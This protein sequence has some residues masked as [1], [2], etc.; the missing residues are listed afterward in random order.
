MNTLEEI[1]EALEADSDSLILL[2][3]WLKDNKESFLHTGSHAFYG[4]IGTDYDY[5][6]KFS[7]L[8][9]EP[10]ELRAEARHTSCSEDYMDEADKELIRTIRDDKDNYII[11]TDLGYQQWNYANKEFIEMISN[12]MTL[13]KL[14]KNDKSIRVSIFKGLRQ[15]YK[16]Y[17]GTENSSHP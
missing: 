12:Y 3:T 14:T 7:D 4:T 1:N 2:K 8:P 10:I 11:V 17:E 5:V 15:Q 13:Y 9:K 16:G 6:V